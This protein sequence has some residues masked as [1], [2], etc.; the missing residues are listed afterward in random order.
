MN[1]FH[2]WI[3]KDSWMKDLPLHVVLSPSC[4]CVPA[5]SDLIYRLETHDPL[6]ATTVSVISLFEH[7]QGRLPP[8]LLGDSG[9][10]YDELPSAAPYS[11]AVQLKRLADLF[12]AS[13]LLLFTSPFVGLAALF[14]WLEDQGP[15][16]Y[17]QQRSGLVGSALQC[18]ETAHHAP[19]VQSYRSSLDSTW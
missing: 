11:V 6:L 5:F 16:F 18:P 7:H 12:V 15:I 3:L 4:R 10:S 19:P 17:S 13:F 14:I 2:P 9:C 1:Q 8:T